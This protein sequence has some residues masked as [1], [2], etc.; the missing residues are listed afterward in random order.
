MTVLDNKHFRY[1]KKSY[2][3]IG[4][5]TWL[6][7]DFIQSNLNSSR[8]LFTDESLALRKPIPKSLEVYAL[9]SGLSFSKAFCNKLVGIQQAISDVINN[10]LHYW[11][12]PE[13]FGVEYCVFKWPDETWDQSWSHIIMNEISLLKN[14]SFQFFIQGIQINQ[15]GC[16][17]AR[18]Y[19]EEGI[20]FKIREHFKINF[21]FLPKKQSDWAHVPIGRILE[22][23]G[24]K[25]FGDLRRLVQEVSN[26]FIISEEI[27]TLK[28]VHERRWYMEEKSIISEFHLD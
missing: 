16:I 26:D 18:G 25:K 12:L 8:N 4:N 20:I 22:P 9:L 28:F 19:D 27:N 21:S 13:N 10:K 5:K 1:L 2:E 23:I 17:I 3:D 7:S 15:D 11:V 24:S 6:G 14:L